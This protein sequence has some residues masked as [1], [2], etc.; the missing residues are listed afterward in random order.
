MMTYAGPPE[1]R[2]PDT[3][4][5]APD[6]RMIA[7][8]LLVAQ[9]ALLALVGQRLLAMEARLDRI[10][11]T[12]TEPG[13]QPL[14]GSRPAL[15]SEAV[16]DITDTLRDIVRMEISPLAQELTQEMGRL[17]EARAVPT[18]SDQASSGQTSAATV[19]EVTEATTRRLEAIRREIQT[20][21]ARGTMSEGELA[22]L[23][24]GI[25]ELPPSQQSAALSTLSRSMSSG[26][27]R[28]RF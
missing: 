10:V 20:Y 5:V 21:A 26:E 8:V 18:S 15:S 19:T 24:R 12:G 22:E 1:P 9:T 28:A 13:S 6:F 14:A 3:R 4:P 27:I 7:I 2:T 23:E 25:A 11:A 16:A 17:A